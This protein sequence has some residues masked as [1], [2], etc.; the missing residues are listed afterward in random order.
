[1]HYTTI[2]TT[3]PDGHLLDHHTHTTLGNRDD[4]L[5]HAAHLARRITIDIHATDPHQPHTHLIALDDE[6]HAIYTTRTTPDGR[7]DLL[8]FLNTNP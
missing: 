5:T 1:M 8:T 2:T 7:G 6:P 4:A 3:T